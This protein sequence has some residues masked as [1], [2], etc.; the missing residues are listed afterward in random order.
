MFYGITDITSYI[1][2]ALFLVL[3]PGP[4]SIYVMTLAARHGVAAGYRGACGVFLGDAILM[5]LAAMGAASLLRASPMLFMVVKYAGALYLTWIGFN[6]LRA[7]VHTW[8]KP[9]SKNGAVGLPTP[10][11][12]A[13]DTA[14]RPFRTAL[15]NSLMNP[16]AI[17]FF[18]SFFVQFIDPGYAYPALSFLL[19]GLIV[20]LFSA[21]SKILPITTNDLLTVS[22]ATSPACVIRRLASVARNTSRAIF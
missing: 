14:P 2:G 19:Q 17:F 1:L 20:M 9:S 11:D 6:L 13:H 15:M 7:A 21:G 22:G 12:S 4:N 10:D 3:L 18:I 16:T 8:R 5:V